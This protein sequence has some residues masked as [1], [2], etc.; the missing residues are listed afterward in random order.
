MICW[1]DFYFDEVLGPIL[2]AQAEG[3]E[4]R[5]VIQVSRR[6]RPSEQS[7]CIEEDAQGALIQETG[8]GQL[9]ARMVGGS[10]LDSFK[11][12]PVADRDVGRGARET[13]A[14]PGGKG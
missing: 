13:L 9:P 6:K 3:N 1:Q 12:M 5:N 11:A 14:R 10:R 2:S 4:N 7:T 8:L